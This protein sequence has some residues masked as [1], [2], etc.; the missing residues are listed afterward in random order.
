L[1]NALSK[2]ELILFGLDAHFTCELLT[3]CIDD[4]FG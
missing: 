2:K 4:F 1:L 3:I